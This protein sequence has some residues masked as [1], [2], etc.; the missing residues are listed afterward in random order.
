MNLTEQQLLDNYT[1][2]RNIVNETFTGERLDNLNKMYD[3]FED[4]IIVA[5]AS[6]KPNYHYAFAGG[7]VLHVYT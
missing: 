2:L 7:Y 3:F 1:K 4:R 5:P 6:G